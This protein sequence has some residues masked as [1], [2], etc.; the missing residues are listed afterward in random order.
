MTKKFLVGAGVIGIVWLGSS[1]AFAASD[2]PPA[3]QDKT[4]KQAQGP[5]NYPEP[6]PPPGSPKAKPQQ[7]KKAPSQAK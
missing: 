2:T 6:L 1:M 7:S 3:S 5:W 4:V